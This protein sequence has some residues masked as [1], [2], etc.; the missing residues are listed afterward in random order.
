MSK[1]KKRRLAV[2]SI[3]Y[4]V[5]TLVMAQLVFYRGI[6]TLRPVYLINIGADFVGMMVGCTLY[7]CCLI[8]LHKTG[9]D[10]K[11]MMALINVVFLQLFTDACA[12]LLDGIPSLRYLN[13]LDNTLYYLCAPIEALFFWMYT[14]TYLKVRKN[15]VKK[16]FLIVSIGAYVAIAVRIINI[17]TGI[18]FTVGQDGVYARS[19]LYPISMVYSYFTVIAALVAVVLERKLLE[20]YQVYTFFMYAIAPMLVGILTMAVYGLSLGPAVFMIVLLLMYCVLNVSEG[21]E[22]V[23]ASRDMALAAEI[24][25]DAMPKEYPYMPERKDFDL[26]AYMK[27]AK[28]VGGDF[29]DYFMI[30]EDHLGLVIAD[31]SGKGIP[32]ALFMMMAKKLIKNALTSGMSPADTL[33]EVNNRLCEDNK[34]GFFVT[35]WI[36]VIDLTNGESISVNA[37]H[38]HPVIRH[39]GGEYEFI[40]YKHS[41]PVAVMENTKFVPH[42][43]KM[44]SGDSIFVYTDGFPEATNEDNKLLGNDGMLEIMNRFPVANPKVAIENVMVG[45]D[46]Y[47]GGAKQFDDITM[48]YMTYY[49]K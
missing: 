16:L 45:I 4:F 43:F 48:L 14:M 19:A 24:Q 31:V 49:G 25:E 9:A 32:A 20:R 2:V 47:V 36:G 18:Y 15:L 10:I 21:R 17:F 30:D 1:S 46:E 7:V 12:W 27:P 29:Y 33:Y 22:M 44:E 39:A 6:D 40:K 23:A 34:V 3:L 11:Y 28:E 35:V 13:I 8:D 37:G 38:E 26:Y 5:L 41:L 42:N